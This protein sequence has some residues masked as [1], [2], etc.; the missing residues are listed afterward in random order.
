[1]CDLEAIKPLK[2]NITS[3][4]LLAYILYIQEQEQEQK[5]PKS[6]DISIIKSYN[7]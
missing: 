3:T 1:M 5:Q 6:N 7:P 2:G 4:T